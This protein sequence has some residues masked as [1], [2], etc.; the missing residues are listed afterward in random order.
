MRGHSWRSAGGRGKVMD[1]L[2]RATCHKARRGADRKG[3]VTPAVRGKASMTLPRPP[4][5]LGDLPFDPCYVAPRPFLIRK[6]L[7]SKVLKNKRGAISRWHLALL[8]D[9]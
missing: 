1:A 5:Q 7:Q 6:S 4:T 9:N 8:L 3:T 2:P